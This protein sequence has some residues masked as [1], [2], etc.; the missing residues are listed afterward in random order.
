[1]IDIYKEQIRSYAEASKALPGRP[2]SGTIARW[3]TRGRQG[4]RLETVTIGGRRYTS[5][6][7]IQRFVRQLSG[8]G[9]PRTA[10]STAARTEHEQVEGQ[11][12]A[13]GL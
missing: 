3:A 9:T 8:S 2:H 6:E 10:Q 12:E 11:L 4:V 1:M 13:E 7:A 5:L